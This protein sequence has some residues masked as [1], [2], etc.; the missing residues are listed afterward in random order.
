MPGVRAHLARGP[1][2]LERWR[3]SRRS[4]VVERLFC[5]QLAGS[6]NLPVGSMAAL[7][8]CFWR[9][10]LWSRTRAIRAGGQLWIE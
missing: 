7:S 4:S 9:D 1:V 6:S 2:R 5:K 3:A 8:A 10:S